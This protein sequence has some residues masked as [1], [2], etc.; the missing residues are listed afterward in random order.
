MVAVTQKNFWRYWLGGLMLFACLIVIGTQLRVEGAPGG[1]GDHQAAGTAFAID[2]IQTA[3]QREGLLD[4]AKLAMT[5][6]LVFIGIYSLGAL[7]GG[8]LFRQHASS[9]LRKLGSLIAFAAVVFF[10]TD[11]AETICQFIQL[12]KFEGN[13]TLAGIAAFVRPTKMIA[14]IVTFIG[15]LIAL[16]SQKWFPGMNREDT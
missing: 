13:D 14:F 3:W 15:L 6:D 10:V 1:I 12:M 9:P 5:L 4:I 8:L 7:M 11:Y 16:F 2:Q